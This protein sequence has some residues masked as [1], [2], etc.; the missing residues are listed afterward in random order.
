MPAGVRLF[1]VYALLILA[2]IGLSMPTIIDQVGDV[3][4][5]SLP[6]L[7]AMALL[8]FTI[9]TVTLV[10]QRKQAAYLLS[11]ALSSLTLPAIPLTWLTLDGLA[12]RVPLTLFV[13]LVA[14][15]LFAGLTRQSTRRYLNEP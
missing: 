15:L 8:A 11:L 5:V 12:S 9:F 6:G 1:V 13:A 7:V 4:P 10:L 2:A 14:V 3:A